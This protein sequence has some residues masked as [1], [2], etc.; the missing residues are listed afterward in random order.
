[1]PAVITV[2]TS[3]IMAIAMVVIV[4]VI[5]VILSARLQLP[6]NPS[7][8]SPIGNSGAPY[9]IHQIGMF[10]SARSNH[11]KDCPG[12]LRSAANYSI[13]ALPCGDSR[14]LDQSHVGKYE[15]RIQSVWWL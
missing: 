6:T 9:L 2:A 12:Q 13:V 11:G 8:S 4:S 10:R 7:S 3:T 14:L 15:V 5:G 1:M